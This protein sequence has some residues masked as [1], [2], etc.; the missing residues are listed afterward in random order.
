[1]ENHRIKAII[2]L[3]NPGQQYQL[4]RHNIGFRIIDALVQ[5]YHAIWQHKNNMDIATILLDNQAV[6]AVKP[7][8]F[9]NNSGN[10]ISWLK[11]QGVEPQEIMVIHDDLELP[12]GKISFKQGGSARGH[13]G[14]KSI[15]A[16]G[17]EQ[18]HRLRFGIDR[19]SIK[20]QVPQ[21][22]LEKFKESPEQ[23]AHAID[24]AVESLHNYLKDLPLK[25]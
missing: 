5:K 25:T 2:G 21:Y 11:V 19:P 22:V 14:V 15:I 3:G 4:T 18:S 8:T 23:L 24:E 9:M 17:A 1:M 13:N 7:L 6:V 16:A 20:E 10:V 12:F